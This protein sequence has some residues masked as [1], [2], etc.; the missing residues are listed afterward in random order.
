MKLTLYRTEDEDNVLGK[1]LEVVQEYDITLKD[2]TNI[3]SPVLRIRDN[4]ANLDQLANY[5]YLEEFNRYYFI[6]SMATTGKEMWS[7]YLSVDVLESFKEDLL[8]SPAE[9]T[10]HMQVGD[11]L[12]V[13]PTREVR[14]EVDIFESN[15]GF[16]DE[17]SIIFSTIGQNILE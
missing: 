1:T 12:D 9:V 15:K 11:Y 7:L 6:T 16:R 3:L 17:T 4:R 10:R 14:K 8:D 5:A 13:T 2:P